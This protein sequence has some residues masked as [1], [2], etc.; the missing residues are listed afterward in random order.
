MKDHSIE[1]KFCIFS[2]RH[3][4]NNSLRYVAAPLK[5]ELFS[6]M[7]LFGQPFQEVN[8]RNAAMKPAVAIWDANSRCA[9]FVV[10]QIKRQIYDLNLV[11]NLLWTY[12][13]R[14]KSIKS[15]HTISKGRFYIIRLVGRSPINWGK[16]FKFSRTH[17]RHFL[18]CLQTT[19]VYLQTKTF[20]LLTIMWGVDQCEY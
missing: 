18:I 2:S 8:R 20:V 12:L 10:V 5:L 9:D 15:N 14:E 4:R 17:V 3:N 16:A 11:K 1:Q 6:D 13:V 7:I 19:D